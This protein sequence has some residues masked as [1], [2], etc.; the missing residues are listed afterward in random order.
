MNVLSRLSDCVGVQS[1]PWAAL[2]EA[3]SDRCSLASLGD[4]EL[5]LLGAGLRGLEL[6]SLAGTLRTGLRDPGLAS[7]GATVTA[8]LRARVGDLARAR[9]KPGATEGATLGAGDSVRARLRRRVRALLGGAMGLR[10]RCEPDPVALPGP[11]AGAAAPK[12]L[13]ASAWAGSAGTPWTA[14]R[15]CVSAHGSRHHLRQP[16]AA[17]RGH[18]RHDGPSVERDRA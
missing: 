5:R 6:A 12:V 18:H 1:D 17:Y 14:M 16:V 3:A 15:C 2:A 9:R 11:A 7:L 4:A 10:G 13:C 8:G